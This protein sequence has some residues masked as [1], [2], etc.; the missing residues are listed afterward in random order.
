MDRYPRS[1]LTL[2]PR[3]SIAILYTFT[4][5]PPDSANDSKYSHRDPARLVTA[6]VLAERVE[7]LDTTPT[8][9]A[10]LVR[11]RLQGENGRGYDQLAG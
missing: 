11:W 4:A 8:D 5:T 10:S 1:T 2:P 7:G 6:M 9:T 3:R